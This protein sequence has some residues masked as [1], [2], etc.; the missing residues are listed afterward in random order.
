MLPEL[1][2]E[3]ITFDCERAA[4]SPASLLHKKFSCGEGA[5][6]FRGLRKGCSALSGRLFRLWIQPPTRWR[7]RG[8][9]H[10]TRGK[11]TETKQENFKKHQLHT[12]PTPGTGRQGPLPEAGLLRTLMRMGQ[13]DGILAWRRT[14][15]P[16]AV[17]L[18]QSSRTCPSLASS[19]QLLAWRAGTERGGEGGGR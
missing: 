8:P 5:L 12:P 9:F 13:R 4:F 2:L 14:L 6:P 16:G 11:L 17:R 10:D 19:G 15:A 7:L 18:H 3:D 1:R